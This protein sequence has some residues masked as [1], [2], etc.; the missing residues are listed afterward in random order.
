MRARPTRFRSRL[1][2]RTWETL[3]TRISDENGHFELEDA[4]AAL[5]SW[6]FYTVRPREEQD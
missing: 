2:W 4:D 3:A 6:R 5:W 1:T